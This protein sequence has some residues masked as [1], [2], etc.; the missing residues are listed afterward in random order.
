MA[1]LPDSGLPKLGLIAGGGQIP[2]LI[3]DTCHT[4]GRPLY[5]AALNGFCAPDTVS[6]VE[7]GWFDLPQVG[8]LMKALKAANVQDVCLCGSVTKPDFSALK[9]DL[10]GALLLPRL[11]K[12]AL[13]GDDAILRVVVDAF[14]REGFRPVGADAL[15]ASL[16]VREKN[17]GSRQPTA[18]Q[19][20]DVATALA[21][22]RKLGADDRGQASVAAQGRVVGLEDDSGTDA[23]LRRMAAEPA[24]RGGVLVKC[25]K[26]Q[27]DRRVDLPTIGVTTVENAAAAGLAGIAIEAGAALMVDAAA[28]SGAADRL[29]LFLIGLRHGG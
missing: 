15:M 23:L 20:A 7:H 14:E 13:T 28:T 10:K 27:Q 9:P 16:L 22:A 6:G 2:A 3:R 24:A 5:I 4:E 17:Y 18:G 26:P 12:A 1:P 19:T 25:A 8:A 11:L 29:G 21:A